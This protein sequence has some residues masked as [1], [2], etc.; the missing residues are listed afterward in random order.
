MDEINESQSITYIFNANDTYYHY[1]FNKQTATKIVNIVYNKW[2]IA[3]AI[4]IGGANL[5]WK[6]IE[7]HSRLYGIY[8]Y[9]I[10]V[11]S[12]CLVYVILIFLTM[13]RKVFKKSQDI[14]FLGNEISAKISL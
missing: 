12:L 3:L 9:S 13:N 4:A 14:T 11:L 8:I 6:L 10:I 1:L 2:L 7:P 5:I